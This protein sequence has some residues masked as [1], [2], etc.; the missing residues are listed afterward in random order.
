MTDVSLIYITW[1]ADF[2]KWQ[3]HKV[4]RGFCLI[5][6]VVDFVRW[7][8]PKMSKES[9]KYEVFH[10]CEMMTSDSNENNMAPNNTVHILLLYYNYWSSPR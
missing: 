10:C 9:E 5:W 3:L 4:A 6:W 8:V 7:S 1:N 2:S